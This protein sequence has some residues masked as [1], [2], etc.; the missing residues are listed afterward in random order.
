MAL[1]SESGTSLP[2][3][4]IPQYVCSRSIRQLAKG[5]RLRGTKWDVFGYT[6]ERKLERQMITDYEAL[7]AEIERRLTPET[8]HTAIALATLPQDIKGFGHV[9]LANYEK[10]KMRQAALLADLR[11]PKPAPV[12]KAAE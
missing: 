11:D 9:K 3:P 8:H 4:A 5:K 2:Y 7:L 1:T 12:L 10:A 6:S